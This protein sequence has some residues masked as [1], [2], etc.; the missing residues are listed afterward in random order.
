[1]NL[2]GATPPFPSP[3]RGG[4]K[5][6]ALWPQTFA[7]IGGLNDFPTPTPTLPKRGRGKQ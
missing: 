4:N 1:M 6:G 3:L 7:F 2:N 5:A